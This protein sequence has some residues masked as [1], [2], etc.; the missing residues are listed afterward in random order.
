MLTD[1]NHTAATHGGGDGGGGGGGGGGVAADADN[2]GGSSA[3]AADARGPLKTPAALAGAEATAAAE[4]AGRRAAAASAASSARENEAMADE[5]RLRA[6]WH[7]LLLLRLRG[8]RNARLRALRE[9]GALATELHA[10]AAEER[11]AVARAAAALRLA[12]RQLHALAQREQRAIV[13]IT[14]RCSFTA[15]LQLPPSLG[16]MSD[17]NFINY[18]TSIIEC[19]CVYK[20]TYCFAPRCPSPQERKEAGTIP[21]R[22]W[23]SSEGARLRTDKPGSTRRK[24]RAGKYGAARR[25]GRAAGL[26]GGAAAGP[27]S[28]SLS[29]KRFGA[30]PSR[31]AAAARPP[32]TPRPGPRQGAQRTHVHA[33]GTAA[34]AYG[35]LAMEADADKAADVAEGVGGSK[36]TG[37]GR[38][39]GAG[40]SAAE[41]AGYMPLRGEFDVEWSNEAELLLADLEFGVG[42]DGTPEPPEE[43]TLKLEDEETHCT[44]PALQ[45]G[46]LYEHDRRARKRFTRHHDSANAT[47][48]AA[49]NKGG[50]LPS[51]I[52][53][54]PATP[55]APA[56]LGG[57]GAGAAA[58]PGQWAY[59]KRMLVAECARAGMLRREEARELVRIDVRKLGHAFDF[60]VHAG[61]LEQSGTGGRGGAPAAALVDG[62]EGDELGDEEDGLQAV[63]YARPAAHELL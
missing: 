20:Y 22:S 61:W 35:V 45:S 57:S 25:P 13:E 55:A 62:E 8:R 54:P 46:G 37:G 31:S 60:C 21:S 19:D 32:P 3:P 15:D 34:L 41:V 49:A 53:P 9:A 36:K 63:E 2:E 47:R 52:L 58:A 27:S 39:G 10:E 18:I 48:S 6:V 51:L 38:S 23:V 40:P 28:S 44:A 42:R 29:E 50:K 26:G 24:N 30:S 17:I 11:V 5:L 7:R 59:I 56:G 4:A 33:V 14:C 16:D 12:Q 43:R 1:A